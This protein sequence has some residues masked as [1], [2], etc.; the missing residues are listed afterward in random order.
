MIEV[1]ATA[2]QILIPIPLDTIA[3]VGGRNKSSLDTPIAASHRRSPRTRVWTAL[4]RKH[5]N[6]ANW[7]GLTVVTTLLVAGKGSI[8][9]TKRCWRHDAGGVSDLCRYCGQLYV[10][11][12]IPILT[13]QVWNIA[14]KYAGQWDMEYPTARKMP[15]RMK[16]PT[17][18]MSLYYRHYSNQSQL[19]A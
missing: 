12:P 17:L 4:A 9:G 5:Q 2:I 14:M 16:L 10:V 19:L 11:F 7:V 8:V 18:I 3:P 13:P 1:Q 15:S 6:V